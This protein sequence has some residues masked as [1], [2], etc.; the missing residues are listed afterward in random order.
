MVKVVAREAATKKSPSSKNPRKGGLQRQ[1][2][3]RKLL[4]DDNLQPTFLDTLTFILHKQN[5]LETPHKADFFPSQSNFPDTEIFT[6]HTVIFHMD[7]GDRGVGM[8]GDT[9]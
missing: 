7:K 4:L 6:S 8:Q 9:K 5:K 1:M 2:I 3:L